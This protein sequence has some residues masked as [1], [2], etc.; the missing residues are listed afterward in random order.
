MVDGQQRLMHE[1]CQRHTS[2]RAYLWAL[3]PLSPVRHDT[4]TGTVQT[5][6]L[7]HI[8]DFSLITQCIGHSLPFVV[9]S[10]TYTP[11]QKTFSLEDHHHTT[12]VMD[13]NRSS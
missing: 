8:W 9:L 11:T 3:A 1:N 6:L 13:I 4:L 5:T 7:H 10:S 2:K 12:E